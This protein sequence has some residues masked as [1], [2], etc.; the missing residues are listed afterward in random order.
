[1]VSGFIWDSDVAGH[2][3]LC[4]DGG[5]GWFEDDTGRKGVWGHTKESSNAVCLPPQVTKGTYLGN[6]G[7]N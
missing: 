5:D 3:A 7:W 2:S 4:Q 6:S 1:M